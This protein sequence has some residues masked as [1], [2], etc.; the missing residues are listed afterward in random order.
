MKI[1]DEEFDKFLSFLNV[2]FLPFQKMILRKMIENDEPLR[3]V[4]PRKLG[5]YNSLFMVETIHQTIKAETDLENDP[6][7]R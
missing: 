6:N 4:T 2:D 1:T 7:L 3:I 5:Y